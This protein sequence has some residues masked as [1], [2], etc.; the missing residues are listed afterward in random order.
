MNVL[1]LYVSTNMCR[2]GDLWYYDEGVASVASCLRAAGHTPKF[3]MVTSSHDRGAVQEWVRHERGDNAVLVYLTSLLFSAYGHD[4]PNT[5]PRMRGLKQY[6][7]LPWISQ[8]AP[9]T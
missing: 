3:K 2:D 5:F 7:G 8:A 1:F 6:T 9:V 4:L